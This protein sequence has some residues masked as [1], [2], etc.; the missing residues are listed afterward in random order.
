MG[1]EERKKQRCMYCRKF[2]NLDFDCEHFILA[3]LKYKQTT[4]AAICRC[5]DKVIRL[6]S[7]KARKG[8]IVYKDK[9]IR[10]IGTKIRY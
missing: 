7:P 6:M 10:P 5:E 4:N 1:Q 9:V 3:C 8:T 2:H